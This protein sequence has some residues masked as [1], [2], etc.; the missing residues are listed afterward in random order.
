MVQPAPRSPKVRAGA[1]S[2]GFSGRGWIHSVRDH[3]KSSTVLFICRHVVNFS[4][5]ENPQPLADPQRYPEFKRSGGVEG[6][7]RTADPEGG[8]E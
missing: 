5:G 1:P 6:Q 4:G 2:P 8:S 3:L 7:L